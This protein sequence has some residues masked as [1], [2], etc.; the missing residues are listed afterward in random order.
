A[1]AENSPPR[2]VS[3]QLSPMRAPGASTDRKAAIARIASLTRRKAPTTSVPPSMTTAAP[4]ST[5]A[6]MADAEPAAG[7]MSAA[8]HV[9]TPP[10]HLVARTSAVRMEYKYHGYRYPTS[11]L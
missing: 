3:P 4:P 2:F 5:S 8:R 6:C 9:T 1:T 7:S 11:T 10:S